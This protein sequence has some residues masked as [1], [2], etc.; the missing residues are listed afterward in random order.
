MILH[1][2]AHDNQ[3]AQK[4]IKKIVYIDPSMN[5]ELLKISELQSEQEKEIAL[6]KFKANCKSSTISLGFK[7][8]RNYYKNLT[9]FDLERNLE[10]L[11][12]RRQ[13]RVEIKPDLA[14]MGLVEANSKG[15]GFAEYISQVGFCSTEM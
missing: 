3:P 2:T 6:F 13:G 9:L 12:L 5:P 1:F 4:L 15:G 8:F 14:T 10:K 11:S 7:K